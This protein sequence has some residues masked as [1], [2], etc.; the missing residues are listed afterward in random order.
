MLALILLACS[1][2]PFEVE[3]GIPPDRETGIF[4]TAPEREV[5]EV[6][7]TW[8]LDAQSCA[9]VGA[10]LM[11][12]RVDDDPPRDFDVPCDQMPLRI[13]SIPVGDASIELTTRGTDS[14][15]AGTARPEIEAD[16]VTVEH[17]VLMQV[18]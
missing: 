12:V 10:T 18:E 9:D 1:E 15:F 5:G 13:A 8:S 17:L 16:E 11:H 4:D 7:L 3:P 14:A 6:E 2:Q